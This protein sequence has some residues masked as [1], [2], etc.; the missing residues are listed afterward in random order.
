VDVILAM[1]L[2]YLLIGPTGRSLS[3]DRLLANYWLRDSGRPRSETS[4]CSWLANFSVRLIQVHMCVIYIC[5]GLSKLQGESWWDGSALWLT[6]MMPEMNPLDMNWFTALGDGPIQVI[7]A[8]GTV[9][10]IGYEISF[11]FLIWNRRLRPLVLALAVL[12]HGGIGLFMGLGVFSAAMLT[13]CLAFVD[14]LAM[15]WCLSQLTPNV[16]RTPAISAA[17]S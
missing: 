10:T 1:L 9:L 6:L 17:A 12:L 5:A 13:G 14:P 8:L 16:T 3:V 11:A 7:C 4:E 2:L 15:R